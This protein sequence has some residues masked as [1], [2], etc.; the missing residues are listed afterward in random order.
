MARDQGL[1]DLRD[2]RIRQV[3]ERMRAKRKNGKPVYTIA[4]ILE[5]ISTQHVFVSV[6]TIERVLYGQG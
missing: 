4:Y 1:L 5:H 3:Y 2:K 6:K